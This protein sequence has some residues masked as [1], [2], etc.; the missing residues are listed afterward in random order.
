MPL[1]SSR[2]TGE[3]AGRYALR[4][5][6]REIALTGQA[7]PDQSPRA[8]TALALLACCVLQVDRHNRPQ[9]GMRSRAGSACVS[10]TYFM[11]RLFHCNKVE[12]LKREVVIL[13]AAQRSRRIP[14]RDREAMQRDGRPGLAVS[15]GC[16]AASTSLG[17]TTFLPLPR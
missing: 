9:Q 7:F 13:S 16:V 6:R 10:S 4:P 3:F 8:R 17:M 15:D 12:V 11:K 5:D 1:S 14:L 2:A